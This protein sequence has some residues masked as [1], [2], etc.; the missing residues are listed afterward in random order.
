VMHSIK[1]LNETAQTVTIARSDFDA[2]IEAAEDAEDLAAVAAH[3]AEEARVGKAAARRNY[4]TAEEVERLLDGES[5]L[6][7]WREK[8]GYSQRALAEAAGV[9]SGYLAEIETGK[10]PGSADAFRRLSAVLGVSIKDLMRKEQAKRQLDYGPVFLVLFGAHFV[11]VAPAKRGARADG[12]KFATV[13]EALQTIREQWPA[14]RDRTPV[15]TDEARL[16][17]YD[18]EDLW[19]EMEPATL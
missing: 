10:K 7:I 2:L 1:I 5:P 4:L 11:G 9:P 17:I 15:I 8:R 19:R 6:R 16:P 12:T 13:G 18:T 3:D 14:L